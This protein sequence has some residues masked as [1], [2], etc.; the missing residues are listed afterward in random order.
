[1]P[2]NERLW[3]KDLVL[4]TAINTL[5]MTI[6]YLLITTMAVYA[7]ARFQAAGTG[8]GLASSA[9]ILGA[10]VARLFGGRAV[11]S[12]GTRPVL[13]A[14]L[15]VSVLVSLAYL[16][17]GSLPL[18]IGVRLVHGVAFGAAST[19]VTAAA[20]RLIPDARRGEGTGYYT[21]S[22]PLGAA[23][24]PLLALA[25]LQRWDYAALFLASA[26]ISVTG[27]IL[28][29]L[30]RRGG[31]TRGRRASALT[32]LDRDTLPFS[33]IMLVAGVGS[34]AVLAF[35]HPLAVSLDVEAAAATFFLV[36]AVA[37]LASRLFIGRLQDRRGDNAVIYPALL[38][39]AGSLFLLSRTTSAEG[40]VLA[41]AAV[42]VGFGSLISAAQAAVVRIARLDHVGLA[43]S[44]YYLFLDIG[45][46]LGPLALG[47]LVKAAGYRTMFAAVAL[48]TLA[49][50]VQYHLVHGRRAGA[51]RLR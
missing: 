7:V 40:F 44:T 19:A 15:V 20:Q 24:G 5:V 13:L 11:D 51:R 33:S 38:V 32:L 49:T 16:A 50:M 6:F 12:L 27:V 41:G 48:V 31:R 25:L 17:A 22:S 30:L 36:Y 14:G 37:V 3:S 39:F 42:G 34:S 29:L 8:A 18:L 23:L 28:T 1:M 10:V 46:G 21:M 26:L 43:V 4:A 9:F 35:V 2:S 47:A 45:T